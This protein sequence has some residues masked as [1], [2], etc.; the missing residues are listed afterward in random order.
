LFLLTSIGFLLKHFN[1]KKPDL[2]WWAVAIAFMVLVGDVF[3]GDKNDA[4]AHAVA[5]NKKICITFDDLPAE[6]NYDKAQR[7]QINRGILAA[8]K[9]YNVPAAGF[10]IG[11]NIEGDW[12]ILL[13]WL[14]GG[15]ILGSMTYSGQDIENVPIDLYLDDIYKGANVIE[16]IIRSYKQK[17]RYFRYPYL[18]YGSSS[19]VRK[20]VERFLNENNLRV[21]HASVVTEDFVYN[22]SLEK[23]INTRDSTKLVELGEEYIA[24][25]LERL[26][27]AEGLAQEVVKRPVRHI[28]QLRANRLN[29]MFLDELLAAIAR[30]GYQFISL[31]EALDDRVY[32]KPDGYYEARGAS[33]L[34][35]LKSSN[36]DMIPASE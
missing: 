26:G 33:F 29:S 20:N 16:D 12:E 10:V 3:C 14:D 11:D 9:K 28:L 27:Y 8:L 17:G 31:T 30:N 2:F 5:K 4:K 22:L 34:E 19:E 13:D 1:M 24:H 15:H 35:R 7:R 23:N 25:V 36:P 21:A 6:R 32:S 18:H